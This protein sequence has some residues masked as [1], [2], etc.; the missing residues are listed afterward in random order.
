MRSTRALSPRP[1][2][3]GT[4]AELRQALLEAPDATAPATR[5]LRPRSGARTAR[6]TAALGPSRGAPS[7]SE[8]ADDG[9]VP[10]RFAALPVEDEARAESRPRVESGPWAARGLAARTQRLLWRAAAA[11][12]I[13]WQA[14][15]RAAR[16]W[17]S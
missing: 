17:R 14:P 13:G 9:L 7:G 6:A 10:V 1:Q 4:L 3:R 12:L 5:R 2:E 8:L 15:R 11:V 16:A